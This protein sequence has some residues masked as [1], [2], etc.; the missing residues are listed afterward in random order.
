M[1]DKIISAFFNNKENLSVIERAKLRYSNTSYCINRL[2]HYAT[3]EIKGNYG[4][5]Y[6][7]P[8]Y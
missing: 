2:N 3:K 8:K 6:I 7:V 1:I 4:I 5:N